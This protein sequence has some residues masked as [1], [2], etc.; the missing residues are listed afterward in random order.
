MKVFG[1]VQNVLFAIMDRPYPVLYVAPENHVLLLILT[2]KNKEKATLYSLRAV[3]ESKRLNALKSVKKNA[4]ER[5]QK[6]K[7]R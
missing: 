2:L 5:P 4:R 3:N 6:G 1:T 7:R